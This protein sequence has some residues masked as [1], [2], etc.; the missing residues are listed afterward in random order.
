MEQ[1][2]IAE[3]IARWA[4]LGQVDKVGVPHIEHPRFIAEHVGPFEGPIVVGWL[5]DVVEDTSVTYDDLRQLGILERYVQCVDNLTKRPGE[6]RYDAIERAML[7]PISHWVKI[8]D[9]AHNSCAYRVQLLPEEM[10]K[11]IIKKYAT[12]RLQLFRKQGVV[13]SR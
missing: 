10:Q 7:D 5:H 9:N 6:K 13:M 3:M 12:D 2:H 1:V 11:R 4:H 8:W